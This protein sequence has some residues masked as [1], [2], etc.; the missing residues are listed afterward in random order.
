MDKDTGIVVGSKEQH[1]GGCFK[2][3]DLILKNRL[4]RGGEI[5][6]HRCQQFSYTIVDQQFQMG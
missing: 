2:R 4:K 5:L 3:P 1:F 6:N